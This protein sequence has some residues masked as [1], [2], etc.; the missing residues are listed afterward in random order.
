MKEYRR[1]CKVCGKV[2]HSLVEREQKIAESSK[3]PGVCS[4]CSNEQAEIAKGNAATNEFELARLRQCPDCKSANYDE[5]VVDH[6]A[7]PPV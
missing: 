4:T 7:P 2:W 3:E 5:T 6:S 1:T